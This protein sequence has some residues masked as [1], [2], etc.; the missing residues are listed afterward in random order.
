MIPVELPVFQEV[1]YYLGGYIPTWAVMKDAPNREE[2]IRLLM[3]WS[4]PLVAEKW[5]RYAKAPTG[6]VG[7]VST[8]DSA[9]DLFEQ[10][11][12][13]ITEKYGANVHH[14]ANAGYIFGEDN[15]LLQDDLNEV[16]VQLLDNEITAEQAYDEIK[17][18]VE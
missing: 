9:D 13:E 11:Q 15:R 5:V 6:I 10:F 4:T 2:A 12:A 3:F 1:D 17:G 16:L 14:N 18:Q 8:S 7:H